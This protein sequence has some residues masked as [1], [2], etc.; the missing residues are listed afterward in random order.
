MKTLKDVAAELGLSPDSVRKRLRLLGELNG[1]VQRGP[2]GVLLLSDEVVELLKELERIRTEEG[3]SL[4]QAGSRLAQRRTNLDG[5]QIQAGSRLDPK[6]IQPESEEI[7]AELKR[8]R[9]VLMVLILTAIVMKTLE[10]L[11]Q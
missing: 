9:W 1:N 5:G 6:R 4:I 11:F 10:F 2:R 3:L 8:I 7:L